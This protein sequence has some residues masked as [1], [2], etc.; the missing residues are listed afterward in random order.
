MIWLRFRTQKRVRPDAARRG[1]EEP[2][3]YGQSHPCA[4]EMVERGCFVNDGACRNR[5]QTNEIQFK[6]RAVA[7]SAV[8]ASG[9]F[10]SP[11]KSVRSSRSV[12]MASSPSLVRG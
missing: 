4:G 10:S 3:N 7:A 11:S 12:T 1:Q 8:A 2:V 5:S 9:S 6:Q